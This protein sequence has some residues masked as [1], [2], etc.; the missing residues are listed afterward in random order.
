MSSNQYLISIPTNCRIMQMLCAPLTRS[1]THTHTKRRPICIGHR[2]WSYWP[3]GGAAM[4]CSKMPSSRTSDIWLSTS[5]LAITVSFARQANAAY[6]ICGFWVRL[7]EGRELKQYVI[8]LISLQVKH[9]RQCRYTSSSS[10]VIPTRC[11]RVI[12]SRSATSCPISKCLITQCSFRYVLLLFLLQPGKDA[13][14]GS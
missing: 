3:T 5:R 14:G 11:R 6:N 12:S 8:G 2:L 13:A 9:N 1:H 10:R 4:S 7:G